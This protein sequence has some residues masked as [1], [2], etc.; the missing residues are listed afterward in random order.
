MFCLICRGARHGLKLSGKLARIEAQEREM[1]EKLRLVRE[2]P[3]TSR[4]ETE[5]E[6]CLFILFWFF[7]LFN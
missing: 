4:A 6:V 5:S 2:Q 7:F 3:S 1:L